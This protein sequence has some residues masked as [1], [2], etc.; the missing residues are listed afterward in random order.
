LLETA[1]DIG[2]FLIA[3]VAARPTPSFLHFIILDFETLRAN[4]TIAV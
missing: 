2:L 4:T 1:V 3:N